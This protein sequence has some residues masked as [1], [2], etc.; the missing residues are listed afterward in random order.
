MAS[1]EEK[2]KVEI[3][4]FKR[5]AAAAGLNCDSVEKQSPM[6]G[7]PD[8]KC[9]ID[10]KVVFFELTEACSED[11]AKAIA[12]VRN[13]NDPAFLRAKD[14]TSETYR[15]K[16]SKQYAVKEP[17]ELLIYNVGRT[18]LSDDV[19]I[20]NIRAISENN[21]GPFRKVWYFGEHV[22]EL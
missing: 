2:G 22:C 19:L 20:E 21:K 18:L 7:K 6:D 8:L 14:Y 10:G 9:I 3:N 12:N 13:G 16:I 15:R 17:I 1:E 4:I 5:F 11:V